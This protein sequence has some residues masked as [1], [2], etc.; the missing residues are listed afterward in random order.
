MNYYSRAVQGAAQPLDEL[1]NRAGFRL[2][3]AFHQQLPGR[4]QHGRRDRFLVD[5]QADN[6]SCD[7]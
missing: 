7:P 4:I 3:E 1:E 6:T 2:E 5:I